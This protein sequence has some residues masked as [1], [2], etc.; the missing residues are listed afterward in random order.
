[1]K[2]N[3]ATGLTVGGT[4]LLRVFGSWLTHVARSRSW[5]WVL[6]LVNL[7]GTVYGMYWYWDQLA[8][9]PI[10]YWLF[11]PDC[12]L[13]SLYFTGTIGL[14]LA[15]WRS[16]WFEAVS[17][18]TSAYFGVWTVTVILQYFIV[19]STFDWP[20]FMLLASH[21]GLGLEGFL[22]LWVYRLRLRHLALASGWILLQWYFDYY[23][24][25]HPWLQAP[26]M[27]GIVKHFSWV[28]LVLLTL[29][30]AVTVRL[31][32]PQSVAEAGDARRLN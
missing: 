7:A 12:P 1:M 26:E 19:H 25:T 24:G 17:F 27:V 2:P 20:N 16:R 23:Q 10:Y 14:W 6:F 21:V 18:V 5:W 28:W 32:A 22:F 15:G 3:S 29:G 4:D 8:A 9:T 13:A 31:P 11:T 30:L